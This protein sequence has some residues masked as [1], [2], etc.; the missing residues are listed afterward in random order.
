[1]KVIELAKATAALGKYAS[2]AAKEPVIVTSNGKPIAALLAIDD[3]DLETLSLR[4]NREFLAIM[5]HS[6][7]RLKAE[8][9][10]SSREMRRRLGV[11]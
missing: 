2:E 8:G 10:I 9:G 7:E 1:M 6:R 11:K 4:D 5:Q 3:V